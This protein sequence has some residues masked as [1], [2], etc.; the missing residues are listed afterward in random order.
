MQLGKYYHWD[1]DFCDG[2]MSIVKNPCYAY[3]SDTLTKTDY[4]IVNSKNSVRDYDGHFYKYITI[5]T[6][7]WMAENL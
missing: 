7:T 2:G 5:G 1:W 4:I 3:S 6:Q